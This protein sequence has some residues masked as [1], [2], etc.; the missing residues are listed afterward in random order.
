[1]GVSSADLFPESQCAENEE[2]DRH[3]DQNREVLPVFEEEHR[4]THADVIELFG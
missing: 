2:R 4:Q 3:D 1:M